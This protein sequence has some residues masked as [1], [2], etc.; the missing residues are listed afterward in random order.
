[1]GADS[2]GRRGGGEEA[3][4]DPFDGF[5]ES[6]YRGQEDLL[7]ERSFAG[8]AAVGEGRVAVRGEIG[9]LG[10]AREEGRES[11]EGRWGVGEVP[12]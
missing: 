11:R 2:C 4:A 12:G 6:L 7:R 8:R 1:M 5:D 10:G 9:E 3:A